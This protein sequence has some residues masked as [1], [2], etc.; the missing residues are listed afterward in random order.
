MAY[1]V[2]EGT[3]YVKGYDIDLI[4]STV[5]DIDK[6]RDVRK[7]TGTR[8]PFSMGSLVRVNN[9]HGIPYIKIGGTAAGGNTSANVIDLYSQRRDGA[10]NAGLLDG[11][12]Q[13]YIGLG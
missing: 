8:V 5:K 10:N 9:V 6:P 1:R 11:T 4:G 13:E 2:S 3:A 7:V 12:G